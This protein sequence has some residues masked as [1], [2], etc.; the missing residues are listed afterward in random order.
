MPNAKSW[1]G[2]CI[3]PNCNRPT[4][5]VDSGTRRGEHHK[6]VGVPCSSVKRKCVYAD[7]GLGERKR[8]DRI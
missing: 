8:T 1:L 5:A 7:A 4:K 2:E 3:F 6:Q